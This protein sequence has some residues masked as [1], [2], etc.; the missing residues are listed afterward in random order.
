MGNG[1]EGEDYEFCPRCYANLTLQKG[2]SS[3]LPYWV[4]KGC[5]ETLI[6]P[7]IEGD[8][9]WV[10]DEC[11]AVLN[12]QK[13]FTTECEGFRCTECGFVNPI[14]DSE[15]YHSE[16]EY[17]AT[18]NSPYR[19]LYDEDALLLSMYEEEDSIAGRE[20]IFLVRNIQNDKQYVLKILD[21]YDREIFEYLKANPVSNMPRIIE[22]IKSTNSLFVIEEF[23]KGKTLYEVLNESMMDTHNALHI[24]RKICSIASS[25]HKLEKPI[26]HRDI[27]PSNVMLSES[28]EV[29]LLDVNAA[30]W[31]KPDEKEDTRLMGTQ[32]YAA[33]EQLGY[34]FL[35]S[36][37]KTDT[38][39][40]G[41]LLNVLTTGKLPKEEKAP[42]EI[43]RIV[44]KCICLEP[45]DRYSD[46]ELLFALDEL[47]RGEYA[48]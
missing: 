6:N 40:I 10:C 7:D 48:G 9:L 39:A 47:I 34:G 5:G 31:L 19:G 13:G 37:E 30:K 21:I 41:I 25:L 15:I 2:Y 20:D 45:K 14:N 12:V 3:E 11:G 42:T 16:E 17:E 38:Y 28:G 18:I 36:S 27:K 35:S 32:H 22:V 33:P 44:E 26:V 29:Y 43:W 46:E 1:F 4:C 24:A 8:I 23:I